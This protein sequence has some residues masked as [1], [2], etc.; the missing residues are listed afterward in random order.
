MPYVPNIRVKTAKDLIADLEDANDALM[1]EYVNDDND[2]FDL[3]DAIK[4][5]F[6]YVLEIHADLRDLLGLAPGAYPPLKAM[7]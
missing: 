2:R 3:A 7:A 5:H 4:E 6:V 1:N